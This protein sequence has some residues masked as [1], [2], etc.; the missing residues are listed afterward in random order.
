MNKKFILSTLTFVIITFA[1]A[2]PW[3]LV[4]FKDL[5]HEFGLY[6]KQDPVFAFGILA[7]LIQG[8]ILAYFYPIFYR[9]GLPVKEGLKF[10]LIFA[11]FSISLIVISLAA[12]MEIHP[13][14]LWFIV[15][16]IFHLLQFGISGMVIGYI[17]G[18]IS[19]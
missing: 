13:L 4:I 11:A 15:P 7:M 1:L 8:V 6:N 10:G 12:K 17:Y 19:E 14:H 3:H 5:Y 16:T 18:N 2:Y 9:G